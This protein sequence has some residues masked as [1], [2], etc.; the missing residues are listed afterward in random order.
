MLQGS[1]CLTLMLL[2][3]SAH[4]TT[5]VVLCSAGAVVSPRLRIGAGEVWYLS[6][7][8]LQIADAAPHQPGIKGVVVWQ[9]KELLS[10]SQVWQ[11]TNLLSVLWNYC[12][13]HLLVDT[14][15]PGES[16]IDFI[17]VSKHA[18][19]KGLG[20]L[21]MRWAE[22]TSVAIMLQRLP[23]LAGRDLCRILLRVSHF[24]SA[25]SADLGDHHAAAPP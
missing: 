24:A 15:A 5:S 23:D 16:F 20:S 10:V 7:R 22:Q 11:R 12:Y 2:R 9:P 4:H 21:L 13:D 25:T 3:K 18:R 8:D 1:W 6:D 19:G 14:L 17:A